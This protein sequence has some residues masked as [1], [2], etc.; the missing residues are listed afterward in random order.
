MNYKSR[1]SSF[2]PIDLRYFISLFTNHWAFIG[3]SLFITLLI[4]IIVNNCSRPTYKVSTSLVIENELDQYSR[5]STNLLSNIGIYTP[6]NNFA[7]KLQILSSSPIINDVINE[8][9]FKISY[10]SHESWFKKELYKSS[11]FIV[12]INPDHP[13]LTNL[14][15]KIKIRP[16]KSF[17]LK[18]KGEDIPVYNYNTDRTIDL[19]SK[20]NEER[21]LNFGDP[22]ESDNYDFKLF[23]N[24]A[25][26]FEDG[27]LNSFSFVLNRPKDI[28]NSYKQILEI[29]VPDRESTVAQ[30]S[31][32]S[33]IPQ[34]AIDFLN[35]LKA[36]YFTVW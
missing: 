4:T 10:Y 13:Q 3:S 12:I 25:F 31:I 17:E 22:V 16:D 1:R 28:V 30:L 29:D 18:F 11:P 24:D 20:I 14:K 35:S 9:D 8:L 21:I 7:N 27:E 32:K 36:T 34:K 33:K 26:Q 6:D 23:L 5:A 15:F 19:V 2:E